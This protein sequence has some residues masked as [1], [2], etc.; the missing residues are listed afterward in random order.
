MVQG[1]S[2]LHKQINGLLDVPSSVYKNLQ[3]SWWQFTCTWLIC[4]N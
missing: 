3:A 2:D 1:L 4:Q